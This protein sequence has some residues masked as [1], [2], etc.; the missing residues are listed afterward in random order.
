MPLPFTNLVFQPSGDVSSSLM[1]LSVKVNLYEQEMQSI[2]ES[3]GL[4]VE[5]TTPEDVRT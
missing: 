3:M 2:K 1:E 5:K 4:P